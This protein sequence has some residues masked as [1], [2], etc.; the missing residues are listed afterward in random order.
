MEI[1]LH[2]HVEDLVGQYDGL[3]AADV[4]ERQKT[5]G[6]LVFEGYKALEDRYREA[7]ETSHYTK[8]YEMVKAN[9]LPAI[10]PKF[11]NRF[12][13]ATVGFE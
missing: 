2:R 8:I 7:L 9:P 12:L 3:I 4:L 11:I 13:Q 10:S 6:S 1:A 5:E